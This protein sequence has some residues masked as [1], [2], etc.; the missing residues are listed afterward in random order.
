[1]NLLPLFLAASVLSSQAA[2]FDQA[3]NALE[4][5]LP[6]IAIQLLTTSKAQAEPTPQSH[7]SRLLLAR[8]LIEA[9]QADEAIKLLDPSTEDVVERI[10]LARAFSAMEDWDNALPHYAACVVDPLLAEEALAGQ[11]R[12]LRNSGH[13]ADALEVLQ[14]ALAGSQVSN[15]ILFE[16]V[17]SALESNNPEVATSLLSR[18]DASTTAEKMLLGFQRA[19][20]AVLSGDAEAALVAIEKIKPSGVAMALEVTAI[21]AKAWLKLGKTDQAETLLEEFITS[22]PE[23]EGLKKLFALLDECYGSSAIASPSELRRWAEDASNSPAQKLA[24][25]YLA[26]FEARRASPENALRML[27]ELARLPEDNPMLEETLLELAVLRIRLGLPEEAL[28]GLPELGADCHVDF[29]RGLALARIGDH[30]GAQVA[31]LNA[32]N[33]PTLS[34]EALFNAS[35][36]GIFD[37]GNLGEAFQKLENDHPDAPGIEALKLHAAFHLAEEGSASAGDALRMLLES[38]DAVV[39]EKAQ[40]ALAEWKFQQLDISGAREELVR[41]SS[42][43]SPSRQAALEVFLEDNGE[44][45]SVEKIEASARNFFV[46]HPEA[47][48]LPSV[49]MKLGEVLFRKG[50]YA[51]ARVELESLA[52]RFPASEYK[53]TA[54]FLAAQS[55]S[56]MPV[57]NATEDAMLL[58]EEVAS[59]GGI[60]SASARMEQAAILAAQDRPL[61]ANL[62]LERI[63]AGAPDHETR[64]TALIEKGKN[65]FRL[66]DKDPENYR[67]AIDVWKQVAAEESRDALWRNQAMTRIGDAHEKLGDPMAAITAYY[68]VFK[69]AD[70]PLPEFFW[71]YKAGFAAGRLLEEQEKWD[72]AIQVYKLLANDEGPRSLEAKNRINQL[73]LEHFLWE[74]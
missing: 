69:P 43:A 25:Y 13:P 52:R 45:G 24:L 16:A 27:E 73:R 26:R 64:A 57:S 17:E 53:E 66:G 50:D 11:A 35:L 19:K 68:D 63:L 10:F 15:T 46:A 8:A 70:T 60:L 62:I 1:M 67:L 18:I 22:H 44:P 14:T 36:C 48:E 65:L 28:A 49:W 59:G 4:H 12:V 20:T 21:K 3:K 33:E 34:E 9:G 42:T 6:S 55:A 39:A 74:D 71:F 41:V 56:R 31:F 23:V 58:F 72:E 5:G 37:T 29:L 30:S 7:E 38:N 32:A 54:L 40:L 47:T 61:E 2:D 51:S